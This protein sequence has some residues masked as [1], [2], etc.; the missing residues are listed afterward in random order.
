M[1]IP[2]TINRFIQNENAFVNIKIN[3]RTQIEYKTIFKCILFDDLKNLLWFKWI[4]V[5]C[6]QWP[7][8][9]QSNHE[10]FSL[11]SAR[12]YI[13]LQYKRQC[14][15]FEFSNIERSLKVN[16]DAIAEIDQCQLTIVSSYMNREQNE[17][18]VKV[19]NDH[20]VWFQTS[21]SFSDPMTFF[22]FM[23]SVM[24]LRYRYSNW[25]R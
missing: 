23:N 25:Y 9:K 16:T 7:N 22:H 15:Y 3:Y 1:L 6:Q 12:F 17:T 13:A 2:L 18:I 10:V 8:C 14:L 20:L 24:Q 21:W 4:K 11:S 19:L 5:L